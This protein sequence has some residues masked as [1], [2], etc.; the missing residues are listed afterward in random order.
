M[1]MKYFVIQEFK[2]TNDVKIEDYPTL[3]D[4]FDY[5]N[6][7]WC[8]MDDRDRKNTTLFAVVKSADPDT[9]S[10]IHFTGDYIKIYE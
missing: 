3:K 1:K 10:D 6:Y 2:N 7:V 9:R 4:A 5:A 8:I